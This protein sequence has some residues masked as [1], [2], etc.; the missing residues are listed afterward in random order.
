ME[1]LFVDSTMIS[2][3]GYDENLCILEIEFRSNTQ[4]WS[5]FDFP[6]Y[7]W[8]EFKSAPSK[9]KYFN[10]KIKSQYNGNRIA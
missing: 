9:G 7:L 4:V 2:R 5:Y 3:I 10:L 8:N 6:E 1:N